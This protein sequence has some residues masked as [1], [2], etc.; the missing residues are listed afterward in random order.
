VRFGLGWCA[1]VFAVLAGLAWP[2][3]EGRAQDA[4]L[5][6]I[7]EYWLE[8]GLQVIL[9]ED[10]SA[11]TVAV[12]VW[13][14]VGGGDDPVGRSGF[15]HLFEHLMFQGS[16]NVP[17]GAHFEWIA[18]AGGDTNATTGLDRTNYFE[19]L[20]AHQLP[21]GLWLE[22]ERM[23]SLMVDEA[24]FDRER[25]VVKEEYRQR[26]EN[27]AY[28]EAH[29]LLQT[30]P[31]AY[32][33]YQQPVIGSIADLDRAALAEVQ[34]FH[35]AYY[36]PNNAVLVVAGDIDMEQTRELVE[37]Y[38]GDIPR[39]EPAPT[40]PPYVPAQG[41]QAATVTLQDDLAR[42]PATFMGYVVPPRDHP[43]Y[44]AATVLSYALSGGDSSRLARVLVDPG[45]AAAANTWVTGN[46]GPSL[47]GVVLV[48]NQTVPLEMLE[49][50][51]AAQLDQIREEGLEPEELTKV[52]NQVRTEQIN[53]LQSA[54]GLAESVQAANFY[55]GD[56]RAVLADIERFRAVTS[57]DIQR[58]AREYL[59]GED[60]LVIRVAPTQ[61]EGGSRG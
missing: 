14:Q 7:T 45:L 57:E 13:Y 9:V 20:P 56:P 60:R 36:K 28:G 10:H 22:A 51:Y 43:D 21:L 61:R 59:G 6:A 8:N 54:L 47:F 5:R 52:V 49:L 58:V 44:Y 27:Q 37:R 55:L 1:A 12:D 31:F 32:A 34:A 25:E 40:R 17:P 53:G 39:Q 46:R 33:P 18:R 4:G 42:V 30:R 48:P 50:I 3:G 16:G 24:N 23:R 26:V 38:F 15:A 29:L 35:D 41:G 2:V 11:P 19:V